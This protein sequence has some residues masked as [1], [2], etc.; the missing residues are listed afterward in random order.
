MCSLSA[1]SLRWWA[2]TFCAFLGAFMVVVPGEFVGIAYAALAPRVALWGI[3]FLVSGWVMLAAAA[4]RPR[5][6]FHAAAHVM[7]AAVF[8]LLAGGFASMEAWTGTIVYAVLA[9]GI[10]AS[11]MMPPR[12]GAVGLAAR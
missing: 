9:L 3:A 7:V 8:A 12:S 10:V 6:A 5:P 11:A 4:T 2:G 1:S